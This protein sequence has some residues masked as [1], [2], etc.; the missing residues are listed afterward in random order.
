MRDVTLEVFA[1]DDSASVQ[2]TMY[3]MCVE[4]LE[5]YG[6]IEQVSYSLPNKHYFAFDLARFGLKNEGKDQDI[7]YPVADP[8][9]MFFSRFEGNEGACFKHELSFSQLQAWS[10]VPSHAR[11][12]GCEIRD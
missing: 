11:I 7:F 9:G 6:V 12:P 3:K 5:R 10:L 8:S 4:I 2:A 1:T